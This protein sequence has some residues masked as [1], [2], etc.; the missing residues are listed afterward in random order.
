MPDA[1]DDPRFAD[2]PLVA[3]G[4][5]GSYAGVPL[6]SHTG[7]ALGTLGVI[8]RRARPFEPETIERLAVLARQ[9]QTLLH[10]RCRDLERLD[11]HAERHDRLDAFDQELGRPS[12]LLIDHLALVLDRPSSP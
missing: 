6:V 4:V 2:N 5:V 10:H 7:H 1:T 3:D 8:D 11:Q 12:R 9:V